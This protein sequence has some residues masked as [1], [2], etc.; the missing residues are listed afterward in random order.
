MLDVPT[1]RRTTAY[2]K[3]EVKIHRRT[4][5]RLTAVYSQPVKK[6]GLESITKIH[7]I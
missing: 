5:S 4:T 6:R 7:P 3:A 1:G 2:R